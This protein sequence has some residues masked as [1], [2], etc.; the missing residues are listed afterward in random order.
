MKAS[1]VK[2]QATLVSQARSASQGTDS[3]WITHPRR[4]ATNQGRIWIRPRRSVA[5]KLFKKY[6]SRM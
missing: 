2:N 3:R 1:S 5:S 4:V 6:A